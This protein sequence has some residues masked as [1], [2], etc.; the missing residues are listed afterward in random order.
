ML[1]NQQGLIVS[2]VQEIVIHFI[3]G[4]RATHT[5]KYINL[6]AHRDPAQPS[7]AYKNEWRDMNPEIIDVTCEYYTI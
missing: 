6:P 5:V 3:D 4:S 2:W 1:A 7:A